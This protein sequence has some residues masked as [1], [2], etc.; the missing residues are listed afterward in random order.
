MAKKKLKFPKGITT[1][2]P[3]EMA[4]ALCNYE[5]VEVPGTVRKVQVNA[6][7]EGRKFIAKE[8]IFHEGTL[9]LR[10]P[11]TTQNIRYNVPKSV[12]EIRC[13]FRYNDDTPNGFQAPKM[14][15]LNDDFQYA[16]GLT[17]VEYL[18]HHNSS[19]V[20]MS[21]FRNLKHYVYLG[22]TINQKGGQFESITSGAVIH[23]ENEKVAKSILKRIYTF[24]TVIFNSYVV[25]D[26]Q[27]WKDFP[28]DKL[29]LTMEEYDPES[30]IL[31]LQKKMR[32]EKL[33]AKAEKERKELEEER[34]RQKDKMIASMTKPI[35]QTAVEPLCDSWNILKVDNDKQTVTV[36][37]SLDAIKWFDH[38]DRLVGTRLEISS[39]MDN[40]A[41]NAQ[42]MAKVLSGLK[43]FFQR[44]A[45]DMERLK[46]RIRESVNT[47]MHVD[48]NILLATRCQGISIT[49]I[50]KRDN[51][52]EDSKVFTA[53]TEELD[54]IISRARYDEKIKVEIGTQW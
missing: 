46:M 11:Y 22:S 20:A 23:V 30:R 48:W 19:C 26:A 5:V 18:Q 2:S 34:Q 21:R 52:V 7:E 15:C 49:A 47:W 1:I 33:Q 36:S 10:L 16:E 24:E 35:I 3:Q 29:A 54:S 51:I 40:I 27:E 25:V 12:R 45:Q 37:V 41:E 17:G 9:E 44:Y 42:K 50:V 28:A 39:S 13:T 8:L 53:F 32:E 38:R 6:E 31:P 43:D 14:L 4:D